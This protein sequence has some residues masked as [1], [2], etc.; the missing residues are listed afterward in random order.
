[1]QA[2]RNRYEADMFANDAYA[3]YRRRRIVRHV[4]VGV[5]EFERSSSSVAQS[6]STGDNLSQ[7][8]ALNCLVSLIYR[9]NIEESPL[10]LFT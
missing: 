6:G 8:E 7:S 5:N 9:M 2:Y 3:G 1:M 4:C 10:C